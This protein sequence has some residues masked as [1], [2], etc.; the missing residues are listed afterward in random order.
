MHPGTEYL[1][2][3]KKIGIEMMKKK[4]KKNKS[5]DRNP[6]KPVICFPPKKHM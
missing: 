3:D 1:Q 6:T 4:G 5:V 2:D